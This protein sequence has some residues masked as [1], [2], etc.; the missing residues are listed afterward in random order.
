MLNKTKWS[1][2]QKYNHRK[3]KIVY[4]FFIF[5]YV[6]TYRFLFEILNREFRLYA[7]I[8]RFDKTFAALFYQADYYYT[9]KPTQKLPLLNEMSVL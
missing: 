8:F 2:V 4:L 9:V 7:G 3:L 1:F 6:S 5:F